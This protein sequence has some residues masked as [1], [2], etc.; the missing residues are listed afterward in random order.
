M[1]A[2]SVFSTGFT[3]RLAVFLPR[4]LSQLER[5]SVFTVLAGKISQR[6][7]KASSVK[8]GEQISSEISDG[9]FRSDFSSRTVVLRS[10]VSGKQRRKH[11][12]MY[13]YLFFKD[14]KHWS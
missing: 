10:G 7:T 9:D 11:T 12:A 13:R 14:A 1:H 3:V 6:S 2:A 5:G 8:S 4:S